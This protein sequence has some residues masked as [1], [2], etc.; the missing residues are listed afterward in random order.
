MANDFPILSLSRE[1]L[2][3]VGYAHD[4][5]DDR[6]MSAM[7]QRL[8][9]YLWDEQFQDYLKGVAQEF[10]IPKANARPKARQLP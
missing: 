7:A 10:G 8:A 2:E 9:D 5:A 4:G 1:D 3:E 6:T